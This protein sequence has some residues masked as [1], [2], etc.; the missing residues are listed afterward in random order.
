MMN[1][2]QLRVFK[3]VFEE[4][5]ITAAARRL[6]ISQPAVSKQL[7]ELES[8]L[9]TTLVDRLPRGVRLTA[10]GELL[11]AHTRRIFQAEADAEAALAEFLGLNQGKLSV[12]ASTTVG[13]YLVPVVFGDFHKQH[14]GV[15]LQL[16]IGNTSAIQQALREGRLDVGLTEGLV[17]GEDLD[18]EVFAHDEIVLIASPDHELARETEVEA[19]RLSQLPLIL[20][21]QGS[22]TRDVIEA[23]L[24]DRGISV[25]PVMSLGGSEAVKNAV[26]Q[27]LGLALLSRLTVELELAVGRFKE[28]SLRGIELKRAL[29]LLTLKGK[30]P[31]PAA[32]EFLGLLR[33][34]YSA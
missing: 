4:S 19:T 7:A 14:P 2:N 26:A 32:D 9:G 23:A 8:S 30:H 29:H 1:L 13:S 27:G 17:T 16:E 12:G 22:G 20:R 24:A 5:S 25:S 33:A 15:G 11:Q 28:L 18:V 31:S 3:A 21:E 34:R 10:A 6:R